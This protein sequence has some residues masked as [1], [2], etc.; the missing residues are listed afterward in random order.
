MLQFPMAHVN[1]IEA[2]KT[3]E[4]MDATATNP[5]IAVEEDAVQKITGIGVED[6][7]V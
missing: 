6:V 2:A 5:V 7:V 4:D 1:T 3:M